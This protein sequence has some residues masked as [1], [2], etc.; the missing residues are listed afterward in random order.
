M[1]NYRPYVNVTESVVVVMLLLVS[2]YTKFFHGLI[3]NDS[4]HKSPLSST[5]FDNGLSKSPIACTQ[6]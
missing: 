4:A 6:L 3:E 5:D 2:G 1:N